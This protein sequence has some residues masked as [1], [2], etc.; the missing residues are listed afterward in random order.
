MA[1]AFPLNSQWKRNILYYAKY[2]K[3][4][5]SYLPTKLVNQVLL[6]GVVK[7]KDT[8]KRDLYVNSDHMENGENYFCIGTH[9]DTFLHNRGH[10]DVVEEECGIAKSRAEGNSP[11]PRDMIVS[12]WLV[13]TT[14]ICFFFAGATSNNPYG[15]DFFVKD[16]RYTGMLKRLYNVLMDEL[17]TPFSKQE[18]QQYFAILRKYFGESESSNQAELSNY[19][20]D[21][22]LSK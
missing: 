1:S 18:Q 9:L 21:S 16:V 6:K 8:L 17:K 14:Y 19:D 10:V 20:P 3:S 15:M 13:I 22:V 4:I 12:R 11:E 2:T 5:R 7:W